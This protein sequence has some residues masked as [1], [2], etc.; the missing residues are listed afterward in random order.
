MATALVTTSSASSAPGS[1]RI[2]LVARACLVDVYDTILHI[3]FQA[4]GRELTAL[5]GADAADWNAEWARQ[6]TER[7]LG[8]LSMEDSFARLLRASGIDPR[9]DLV[10]SLVRLDAELMGTH[11]RL[12][13]DTIPFLAELRARDIRIAL[14]SNCSQHTRQLLNDTGVA[15]LADAVILS[16]EVGAMKPSPEIYRRALSDLGVGPADALMVDDQPSYCTG[17][18]AVGVKAVQ[19]VRPDLEE[20][21]PQSDFPVAHSLLD[22]IPLLLW[23]TRTGPSGSGADAPVAGLETCRQ[24]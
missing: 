11:A 5:A 8:L 7:N 21:P 3:G 4:C 22:V 17:A 16:C 24:A 18:Q 9:P 1:G 10:A 20:P 23:L 6:Y 2:D 14:V 15:S 12:Y 19:M 13:D